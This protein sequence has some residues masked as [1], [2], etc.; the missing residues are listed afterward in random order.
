VSQRYLPATPRA[1]AVGLALAVSTTTGAQI[2]RVS[3]ADDGSQADLDSYEAAV[4]DDGSI[5]AFRSSAT[6]LVALD[7]NDWGDIFVRDLSAGTTEMVSLRP[8][9]EQFGFG[10]VRRP[11]VSDDGQFVVFTPRHPNG[12]SVTLLRDR[13]AGISDYLMLDESDGGNPT[14]P[15]RSR[16]NAAISGNGQFVVFDSWSTLGGLF[17]IDIRPIDDDDNE[18]FDVF[19]HD[20]L[21]EPAP[22]VERLSRDSAGDEGRGDSIEP[23]VSDAGR[24][25][26]FHSF[27]DNLVAGDVNEHEDVFVRDRDTD[28]TELVSATPAGEPGNDDSIQAAISGNGQFVA[29][30]SR[31][32]D[33]VAGD[34]NERWDIFVRDRTAGVTERA[35]VGGDAAQA[36]HHS[37]DPDLSD[38]GRFIVFRSLASN[39]VIGDD[40]NRADIFVHDRSTGQTAIVS[41][42]ASGESNGTS[43]DP[44]ISGDGA[45][46][47]FESDATNLVAGDTNGARDVFRAPNPLAGGAGVAAVGETP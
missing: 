31:A 23:S 41:R 19:I 34:T 37:T 42:P 29:F 17:E 11:A 38:D 33:L 7:E 43:H 8:D 35:S 25:V 20:V 44:A 24:W 16:L 22:Q 10:P 4:S 9:G 13:V 18:T 36:N 30:R 12:R 14:G 15:S 1:L 27:S 40:N 21:T 28:T 26:A 47:V 45:W 3:L 5:V 6:N 39:L 32:T 46:I 2:E